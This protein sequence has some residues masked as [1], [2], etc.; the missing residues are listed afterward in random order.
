MEY[1]FGRV[2]MDNSSYW[3]DSDR[4]LSVKMMNYWA[5][6]AKYGKLYFYKISLLK[7]LIKIIIIF[8]LDSLNTMQSIAH[9]SLTLHPIQLRTTYQPRPMTY[10]C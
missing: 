8:I 2:L 9:S 4:Q 3:F 5:N 10:S 6:F 7:F 1:T